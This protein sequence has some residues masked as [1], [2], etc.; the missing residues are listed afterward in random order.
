MTT[1]H[2]STLVIPE[3]VEELSVDKRRVEGAGYRIV[4]TVEHHAEQITQVLHGD[5]VEVQRVEIG[6]LL[7]SMD[8]PPLRHEGNTTIFSV[9]EEVLV[10]EKRLRLKEEIHITVTATAKHESGEVLL[11]DEKVVIEHLTPKE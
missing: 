3:T 11:R 7:P 2:D 4:K 10:T 5:E 6:R 9:V 8:A 1:E